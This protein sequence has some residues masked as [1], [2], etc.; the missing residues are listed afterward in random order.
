MCIV[1][2]NVNSIFI[3]PIYGNFPATGILWL[4]LNHGIA[5]DHTY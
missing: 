4:N 5:E 3:A 2:R 1:I